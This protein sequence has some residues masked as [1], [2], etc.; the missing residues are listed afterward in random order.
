MAFSESQRQKPYFFDPP[1]N[2]DFGEFALVLSKIVVTRLAQK[3]REIPVKLSKSEVNPG[4][5]AESFESKINVERW[6]FQP[7]SD[8]LPI[9]ISGCTAK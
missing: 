6:V 7:V 1:L 8:G 4:L 5:S 3:Y 9:G 2:L